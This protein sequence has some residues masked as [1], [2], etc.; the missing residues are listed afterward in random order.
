MT[1]EQRIDK[2]GAEFKLLKKEIAELKTKH[3]ELEKKF[4]FVKAQLAKKHKDMIEIF[5]WYL[6]R[7]V[8]ITMEEES[9]YDV[10]ELTKNDTSVSD[11]K[12]QI[13]FPKIEE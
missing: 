13:T 3:E 4:D 12:K 7:L 6:D 9:L 2:A 5:K 11:F 1:A 10:R 8:A